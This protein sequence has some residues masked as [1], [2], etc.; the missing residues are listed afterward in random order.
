MKIITL[1][2]VLTLSFAGGAVLG[3]TND[4]PPPPQ[5]QPDQPQPMTPAA[6]ATP[7]ASTPSG[8]GRFGSI[9]QAF[10]ADFQSFCPGMQPGD[11]KL[12]PC[13][14][15]HRSQLSNSCSDAMRSLRGMRRR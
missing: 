6:P 15:Q 7:A 13:I 9:Q 14:R 5:T 2:A 10:A 12:V 4:T 3:Q 1:A 8:G 11:G